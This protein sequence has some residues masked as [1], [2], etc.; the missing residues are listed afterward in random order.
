MAPNL[1]LAGPP[2]SGKTIK[3]VEEAIQS[4]RQQK[5]EG[6]DLLK[7]LTGLARDHYDAMAR[8]AKEVGISFAGHVPADVGLLHAIQSGQETFDHLD[9]YIEFLQGER[10]PVPDAKLQEIAKLSREAGDREL[11]RLLGYMGA[12][13]DVAPEDS[14]AEPANTAERAEALS[15]AARRLDA[16]APVDL[17]A[18]RARS[19]LPRAPVD[20][21][22]DRH[23][24]KPFGA[25]LGTL[26]DLGHRSAVSSQTR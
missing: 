10:G 17:H 14:D 21:E 12:W 13:D 11:E 24:A 7:V 1:Y 8:T 2:F 9:G 3:S 5:V 16:R 18:E 20:A 6:W 26:P 19:D 22:L 4:V 15:L 23:V 25:P